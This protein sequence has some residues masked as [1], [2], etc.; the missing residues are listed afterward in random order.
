MFLKIR[1]MLKEEV[2]DSIWSIYLLHSFW[3]APVYW[4]NDDYSLLH[5]KMNMI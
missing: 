4:E 1:D 3:F 5:A 2:N